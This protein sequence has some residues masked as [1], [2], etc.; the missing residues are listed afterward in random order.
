M[1]VVLCDFGRIFECLVGCGAEKMLILIKIYESSS[2][3]QVFF[4]HLIWNMCIVC[5]MI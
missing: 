4:G 1:H 5:A 2:W 3:F